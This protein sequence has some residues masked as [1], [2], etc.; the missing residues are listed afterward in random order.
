M[1]TTDDQQRDDPDG[2]A[3]LQGADARSLVRDYCAAH[4]KAVNAL[5][6]GNIEGYYQAVYLRRQMRRVAG[7][8]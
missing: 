2:A 8:G 7:V 3:A 1:G 5:A 4:R 6:T